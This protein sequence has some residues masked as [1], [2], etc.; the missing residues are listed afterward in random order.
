MQN[1]NARE[2]KEIAQ[3]RKEVQ[4]FLFKEKKWY[5]I[6]LPDFQDS[7]N[8]ALND[9]AS[10][11]ILTYSAGRDSAVTA[12]PRQVI[13]C[14]GNIENINDLMDFGGAIAN[15]YVMGDAYRDLK[16]TE[17]GAYPR[18]TISLQPW[19]TTGREHVPTALAA[20]GESDYSG[21]RK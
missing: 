16:H 5:Q 18:L 20:D 9:R 7:D 12:R 19:A 13:Y 15:A 6:I 2:R 10:E 17:R 21:P 11:G 3:M 1:C 14:A 4:K 8:I